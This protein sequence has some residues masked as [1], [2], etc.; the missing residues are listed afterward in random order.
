MKLNISYNSL[1]IL[2]RTVLFLLVIFIIIQLFPTRNTFKYQFDVGKP[3]NYELIT[4]SFDFPI[5]KSS[6][7]IN[8]EKKELLKITPFLF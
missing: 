3:W 6:Q 8:T 4:A 2:L 5:Y 1:Q 7:Q